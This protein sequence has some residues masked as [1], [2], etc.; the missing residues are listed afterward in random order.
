MSGGRGVDGT[1]GR[2]RDTDLYIKQNVKGTIPNSISFPIKKMTGQ[3][4]LYTLERFFYE[5]CRIARKKDLIKIGDRK[6]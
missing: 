5:N 4:K 1:E 3:H 2:D 6:V